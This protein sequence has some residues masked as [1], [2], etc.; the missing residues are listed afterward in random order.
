MSIADKASLFA[1][2]AAP[3]QRLW[4]FKQGQMTAGTI[5]DFANP[6]MNPVA[7]PP[8]TAVVCDNTLNTPGLA[9]C[10][11]QTNPAA[12]ALRLIGATLGASLGLDDNS[13]ILYDRLVHQGGLDATSIAAQ[14]TNLPTPALT[15]YTDG[16]GVWI[17]VTVWTL[18]GTTATTITASY[19]NQAGTAGRTTVA[20]AFGGTGFREF[21]RGIL[22]PLQAGDTGVKSVESVTLAASTTTAGNFGVALIKPLMPVCLHRFDHESLVNML[23]NGGFAP[24]IVNSASLNFLAYSAS[25]GAWAVGGELLFAED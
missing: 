23:T 4:Y 15:R 19:T 3:D 14:T 5:Y 11:G 1:K 16:V 13:L 6:N 25:T 18:V 21:G 10:I 12:N 2:M 7:T 24:A 9:Q 8:T 20:T 17:L 22:L